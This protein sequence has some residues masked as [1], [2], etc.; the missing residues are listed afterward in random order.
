MRPPARLIAPQVQA[1][2]LGLAEGAQASSYHCAQQLVS[3]TAQLPPD[4]GADG[5]DDARQLQQLSLQSVAMRLVGSHQ[6]G[7]AA[8]AVAAALQLRRQGWHLPDQ[9]IAAGLSQAFLPGRFQVNFTVTAAC[10][11]PTPAPQALRCCTTHPHPPT[12]AHPPA[13]TH[14]CSPTRILPSPVW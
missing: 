1:G 2:P 5:S 11:L 12:A 10:W 7:N 8:T 4:E 3:L 13:P 14:S 9:A 6:Q